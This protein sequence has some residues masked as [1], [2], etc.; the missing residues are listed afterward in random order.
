LSTALL[1]TDLPGMQPLV[2]GKVRDMY[3]LGDQML[4][5]AT[6]RISAFDVILPT[7]IPGKGDVLTKMSAFWFDKTKHI[8]NNHYIT[9][10]VN[11]YPPQMRPHYD[12]LAGRSMLIKKADRIDIECVVRGYLA[13]SGWAEY[14]SNGTVCGTSLPAGLKESSELPQAIFTP[15]TKAETGHDENITI[16][17]MADSIGWELAETISASALAIYNYA[18]EYARVRG[19]IIADTKVEFG[20]VDGQVIL[21]DELLTPD[22][23]RFWDMAVYE[24]GRSQP[25]FDKQFVRDWLVASGWNK[26]PPAPKLPPEVV[27]RTTE[28]YSEAYRR[29]VQ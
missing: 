16:Q 25:S 8:V 11:R 18:K 7:G 12:Q 24:P 4:L 26:E 13:G 23:S 5:V 14:R 20:I 15:S 19:I 17:E 3:D 2:K 21:I 22:S 6:D 29:L 27:E 9:C 10:D 1:A 28:K